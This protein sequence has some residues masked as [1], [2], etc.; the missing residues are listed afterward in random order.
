MD[1]RPE[2]EG[3]PFDPKKYGSTAKRLDEQL[4]EESQDRWTPLLR[5]I[6]TDPELQVMQK[7]A[8]SVAVRR[9]RHNDHGPVHMRIVALNSLRILHRLLDGGVQPSVVVE[10]A[11]TVLHAEIALVLAGLLHDVGMGVARQSHEWHSAAMA[12]RFLDRYL[13]KLFPDDIAS[14]WM[15][16]SL[17]REAIVGHMGHERIHSVEAGVLLVADGTDMTSGRSRLVGQFHTEPAVGDMHKLSADAIDKVRIER[18]ATKPVLITAC[19]HD[20]SGIFQVE[21]VLMQKVEASPV[22]RHLEICVEAP[23]EPVRYY[24]K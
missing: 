1:E 18:G 11:G 24:L 6:L 15:V 8:N 5:E 14:Q 22:K 21:N 2:L 12:D 17:V 9:M 16:R 23:G 19:M 13:P 3:S 10:E 4:I 7:W 20:Y